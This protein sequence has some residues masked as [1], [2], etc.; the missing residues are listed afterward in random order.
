MSA[1]LRVLV[2]RAC[3]VD[4]MRLRKYAKPTQKHLQYPQ[5]ALCRPAEIF[6]PVPRQ[7]QINGPI[8]VRAG[9]QEERGQRELDK[10]HYLESST[11]V[12]AA[13]KWVKARHGG[14]PL[15]RSQSQ[16]ASMLAYV[17]CQLLAGPER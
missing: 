13:Q 11:K 14:E 12:K 1:I 4:V 8:S 2:V 3:R 5:R 6:N 17:R 9:Q 15:I 10:I 16:V 7:S